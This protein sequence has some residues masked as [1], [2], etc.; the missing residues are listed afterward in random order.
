MTG[1]AVGSLH[2]SKLVS[3]G[4]FKEELWS[5]SGSQGDQWKRAQIFIGIQSEF[6]ISIEA[7]RG[8][9]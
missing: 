1:Y 5:E 2:V 3:G 6:T 4:Q 7:H 8:E 9:C